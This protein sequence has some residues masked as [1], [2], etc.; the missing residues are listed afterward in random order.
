[1]YTWSPMRRHR[2]LCI[3]WRSAPS[4][5][6]GGGEEGRCKCA[7]TDFS[8][9]LQLIFSRQELL[10]QMKFP[11]PE[12][13]EKLFR[14]LCAK[15]PNLYESTMRDRT[16]NR[17]IFVR[18]TGDNFRGSSHTQTEQD[19]FSLLNLQ[20]L[21]TSPAGQF[22]NGIWQSDES[23]ATLS[24]HLSSTYSELEECVRNGFEATLPDGTVET[25]NVI[26]FYVADYSHKKEVLGRVAVNVKYGCIHCKRPINEW[27]NVSAP[28]AP[29]LTTEEIVKLGEKA[30]RHLGPT[31]DKTS[32]EYESFIIHT[33]DRPESH[34]S[35]ASQQSVTWRALSIP[36]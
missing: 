15:H 29:I 16:K 11:T 25:F 33:L 5:S 18:E 23:R 28:A 13:Q 7:L 3:S 8:E 31:P 4:Q 1:M 19:S 21:V 24:A 10:D 35:A 36:Y 9:T 26:V 14:Q 32:S 2:S 12:Q 6:L 34:C 20:Q 17:T 27:G 30:E 22:V